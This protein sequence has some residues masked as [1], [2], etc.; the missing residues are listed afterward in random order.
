MDKGY[1]GS[2]KLHL[3]LTLFHFSLSK[4]NPVMELFFP[5]LVIYIFHL[6]LAHD[7]SAF[8]GA[9]CTSVGPLKL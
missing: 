5:E 7:R 4:L 3:K 1:E 8:L 2:R 9:F 6:S